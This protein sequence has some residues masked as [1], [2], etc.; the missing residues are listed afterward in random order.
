MLRAAVSLAPHTPPAGPAAAGSVAAIPGNLSRFHALPPFAR[1]AL[2][3][4]GRVS[5]NRLFALNP[6]QHEKDTRA[7]HEKFA[8]SGA[9]RLNSTPFLVPPEAVVDLN[10]R[11]TNADLDLKDK[12]QRKLLESYVRDIKILLRLMNVAKTH[13]V[14][15]ELE[16]D[17]ASGKSRVMEHILSGNPAYIKSH[18]CKAPTEKE[19]LEHFLDRVRRVLPSLGTALGMDRTFWGDS[20][21]PVVGGTLD[22]AALKGRLN[23]SNALENKLISKRESAADTVGDTIVL[24][25]FFH[26]SLQVQQARMVDRINDPWKRPKA[27]L[28]DLTDLKKK[29]LINA[30]YSA[31]ISASSPSHAPWYIVPADNEDEALLIAASIIRDALMSHYEEWIEAALARGNQALQGLVVEG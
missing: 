12:K 24:K 10:R 3:G 8:I 17:N 5:G 13:A 25:L 6:S 7:M 18:G 27:S 9:K 15:V 11:S 28:W 14:L 26:V 31:V 30:A 21:Y 2:S 1:K 4:I 29:P 23:E 16:G 19:K 20:V 22:K